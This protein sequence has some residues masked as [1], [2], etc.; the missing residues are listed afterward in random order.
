[1]PFRAT[2]LSH[3]GDY[4]R[5]LAFAANGDAARWHVDLFA[6]PLVVTALAAAVVGATPVAAAGWA[7]LAAATRDRVP[8]V[9]AMRTAGLLVLALLFVASCVRMAAGTYNPFLY[10][11]F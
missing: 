8:A 6:N 7:R 10:W 9:V 4:L 2:S 1:V 5:A 11:R 3:A